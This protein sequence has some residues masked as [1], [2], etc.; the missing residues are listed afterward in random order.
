M[1]ALSVVL[2]L[3]VAGCAAT[4]S[5]SEPS[6]AAGLSSVTLRIGQTG[7][8]SAQAALQVAGLANTPYQVQW[9]IFSGGD[10]GLQALQAG[11]LDATDTS[12]I[13]PVFAA[14][15]GTPKFKV[16]AVQRSTTLLQEV[17]VGPSSPITNIA[18][19]KGKKVGYVQNTT[20]QY[21]L[22]QLLTK[23]GL[24]WSDIDPAPLSPTDGVAALHSGSIDAFAS[25]GNSIITAH[26]F[27]ARTIGS[28]EDILSGNFEWE[29]ST[30]VI[31]DSTERT[32]L[33][34]LLA[35][36]NRAYA[37]IRAGHEQTY[38]E[39]TAAA[40][41]ES[42]SSALSQ[43]HASEAQRPTMVV[44]TSQAA[45]ASEQSVADV[46]TGLHAIPAHVDVASFWSTALDA[47]LTKALAG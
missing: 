4:S 43:T 16:V 29:A 41:H 46:F 17:V 26:Q 13:P 22:A 34:D 36:L 10:K 15:A 32:A 19:L 33:V 12:D 45:I 38:A 11:A 30:A 42:V 39:K 5:A 14:V 3:A 35:R 44:P 47:D 37:Y 21:F 9:P 1:L 40:T 8:A 6:G 18:G 27:G 28:G 2:A 23:A 31:A 20:A 7:W 25:Y 24:S